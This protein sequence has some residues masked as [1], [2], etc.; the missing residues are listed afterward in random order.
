LTANGE[1]SRQISSGNTEGT[2]GLSWTPDGKIVYASTASGNLDLWIMQPDGS[3]K[4]QLTFDA[5][6]NRLPSVSPDG[7]YIV[8]VSD[9]TGTDNIWRMNMDGSNPKQL[10]RVDG[11]SSPYCSPDGRWVVY[12]S[13][14]SGK[15]SKESVWKVPIDGGN[16]VQVTNT[17]TP[18]PSVSPDGKLIAS[19][20]W[21]EQSNPQQ[22]R[23]A[24]ISFSDGQIVKTLDVP[25]TAVGSTG[26]TILLRWTADGQALTYID[27]RGGFSNIWSQPLDGGPS[28]QLTDFKADR[29]FWFDWSRDGKQLACAR[30][31]GTS[32]VFL[33]KG[34]K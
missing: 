32:D 31:T 1:A 21:D 28:K 5:Q 27:N 19:P 11:D 20:Y 3:G 34:F 9:R 7:R 4:K 33:I 10:T 26:R 8:F 12:K 22:W 13:W 29:I 25:S 18:L 15:E 23:I 24:I 14:P 16:P 2:F 30:G 6:A 17:Q